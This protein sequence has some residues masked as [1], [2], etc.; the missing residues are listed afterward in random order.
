MKPY[1]EALAGIVILFA[2]VYLAG[3]LVGSFILGVKLIAGLAP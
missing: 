1:L 3:A 2:V